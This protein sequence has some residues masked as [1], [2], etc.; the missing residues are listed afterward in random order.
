MLSTFLAQP[1]VLAILDL[2]NTETPLE[3]LFPA[4]V[5]GCTT[6]LTHLNLS[7]NPFSS[8]KKA[9]DVPPAFKQFFAA[10]LAMQYLNMSYCKIPP[11]ALKNLLLGIYYY[12]RLLCKI[13]KTKLLSKFLVV[14]SSGITSFF[15]RHFHWLCRTFWKN[16]HFENMS[17]GFLLRCQNFGLE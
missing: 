6:A 1:N 2:S 7:R 9:R 14:K 3:L 11:D 13:K 5:R 4:L 16:S 10:T 15:Y 17:S 12:Y 8:S